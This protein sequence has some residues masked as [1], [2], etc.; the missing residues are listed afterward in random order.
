[1]IAQ[2]I[3]L[4][5]HIC[6]CYLFVKVRGMDVLGPGLATL[7]SYISMYAMVTIHANYTQSI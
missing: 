5:I 1:M 4:V 6:L 2:I 7:I 3:G